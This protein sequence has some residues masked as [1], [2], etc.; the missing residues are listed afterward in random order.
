MGTAFT[1]EPALWH[2]D[3][4][5]ETIIEMDASDYV[6][7]GGVS[8]SDDERVLHSVAYN[9]KKYLPAECNY[10]I[11]DTELMAII[12]GLEEWRPEWEGTAYPLQLITDL[13]N[14][15]YFRT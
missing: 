15:E 5:W 8:Q 10:D 2:F 13:T 7:A 14:L 6:S 9:S 3:H 1:T 11:Y 4:E 12:D